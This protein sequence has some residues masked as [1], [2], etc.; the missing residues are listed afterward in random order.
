MKKFIIAA[1]L[2]ISAV[3]NAQLVGN[4][5]KS[6]GGRSKKDSITT[7]VKYDGQ[8][9]I[10]IVP[11]SGR[12]F[13]WKPGNKSRSYLGEKYDAECKDIC[14]RYNVVWKPRKKRK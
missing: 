13:Y 14:K 8:Y 3:A 9:T 7:T 11:R 12:C 4:T 2:L 5:L 1:M 10:Y 6:N